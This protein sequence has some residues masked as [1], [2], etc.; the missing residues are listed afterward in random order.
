MLGPDWFTAYLFVLPM[1]LLLGGLIA[2]PFLRAVYMS[3]TNTTSLEIGPFVGFKNYR[4]IYSD[5][6]IWSVFPQYGPVHAD[7]RQLQ[8]CA[9]DSA[10][11]LLL[12]RVTRWKN[13]FT[14]LVLLPWIIPHVVIALTWRNLLDP[15]YGG[16][17]QFLIQT[18]YHRS[19]FSRGSVP[20]RQPCPR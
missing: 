15:I 1:V 8:V 5:T 2:Y 19:R 7:V 17:N 9:W 3:F 10:A 16:V 14:G 18:G 13:V 4:T 20:S 11:A 6:R 12:Q